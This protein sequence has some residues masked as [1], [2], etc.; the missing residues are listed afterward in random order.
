MQLEWRLSGPFRRSV[1]LGR[2]GQEGWPSGKADCSFVLWLET[3]LSLQHPSLAEC[4]K[5]PW[6]TGEEKGGS[7]DSSWI[8]QRCEGTPLT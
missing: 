8:W 5:N 3:F 7:A 6:R 4:R 1:G 2:D